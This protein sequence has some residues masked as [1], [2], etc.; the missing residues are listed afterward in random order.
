[1]PSPRSASAPVPAIDPRGFRDALGRFATGVTVVTTR[2]ADGKPIGVTVNSFAS[3]SLDPPLVSFCLDRSAFSFPAFESA[4]RF[5]VNIL[6][7]QQRDLSRT[8]A[9]ASPADK[10]AMVETFDGVTGCPLLKGALA[11]ID[12]ERAAL[13]DAGDH[14]I[15]IGRVVAIDAAH[16]GAPLLYYRGRYADLAVPD[17]S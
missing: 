16:D 2:D 13:H 9:Q 10:F 3:V 1:M 17:A 6:S 7:D 5:A 11:H 12:C 15:L 14:V 8:F 4:G